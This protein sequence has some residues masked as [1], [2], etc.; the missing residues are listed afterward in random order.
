MCGS[1]SFFRIVG[2]SSLEAGC[3]LRPWIFMDG[4]SSLLPRSEADEI[5]VGFGGLAL[6]EVREEE[7][8]GQGWEGEDGGGLVCVQVEEDALDE[9]GSVVRVGVIAVFGRFGGVEPAGSANEGISADLCL[10]C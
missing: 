4:R 8:P 3:S 2:L 6:A 10:E 9:L 1:V 7:A 5:A